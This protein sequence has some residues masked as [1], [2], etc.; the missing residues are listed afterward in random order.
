MKVHSRGPRLCAILWRPAEAERGLL[1]HLI[2]HFQKGI[3]T[4]VD[5]GSDHVRNRFIR[6]FLRISASMP[7]VCI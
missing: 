7:F 2:K 3:R 4:L 5:L 6:R 1:I